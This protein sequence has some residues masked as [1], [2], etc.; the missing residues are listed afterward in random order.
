MDDSS[1]PWENLLA[2]V[3]VIRDP[4]HG[5]IELTELELS[6]INLPEFQRLRGRKQ[7]GP[8]DFVYPGAVHNRFQH[9]LG[10]V[11]MAEKIIQHCNKNVRL[12][13]F[14]KEINL[15]DHSF[16]RIFALIHDIVHIPF[17]HTLEE[18]GN[19]FPSQWE[20]EERV[21]KLLLN[22]SEII[23]CITDYLTEQ[24]IADHFIDDFI[25]DLKKVVKCKN[26][27]AFSKP[28]I[29]DI[30]NNTVCA[31][32]LDYVSR[33]I[34][35]TGLAGKTGDRFMRRLIVAPLLQIISAD[36]KN[37]SEFCIATDENRKK[38]KDVILEE[39]ETT[40]KDICH[41]LVTLFYQ[42]NRKDGRIVP[43]PSSRSEIIDLMRTRYSLAEKVYFHR[44]KIAASAMLIDAVASS[45]LKSLELFDLTD[46]QTLFKLAYAENMP[47]RTKRI[48]QAL[49]RRRL[50][51]P[52]FRRGHIEGA[53]NEEEEL[54]KLNE[55]STVYRDPRKRTGLSKILEGSLI[56]EDSTGKELSTEGS[57][58]I[59]CPSKK[60]NLKHFMMLVHASK[61]AKVKPLE[62]YETASVKQEIE[63]IK[64]NHE[65]LWSFQIFVD[66]EVVNPT[67]I[68]N[69][70]TI[71][72]AGMCEHELGLSNGIR[73]LRGKNIP[74]PLDIRIE[75]A[76]KKWDKNNPDNIL[77]YKETEL[78]KMEHRDGKLPTI[79][80]FYN[81]IKKIK[82]LDNHGIPDARIQ[83]N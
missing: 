5:D 33:D 22:E 69:W 50:Y 53:E 60:M 3:E 18:E 10:T 25:N 70:Q 46:E 65:A 79:N 36:G 19:L 17:G 81:E 21:K 77:A 45:G 48:A 64:K 43:S 55:V 78:I 20:D 42:I 6:I 35:F 61:E 51:K 34:L 8:T 41:R 56:V 37:T 75:Q 38:A 4:V 14:S 63:V 82:R 15:Y 62:K 52:I 68:S 71:S 29:I 26:P 23:R 57:I 83:F 7:L 24:E 16:I 32:L 31:D 72:L 12:Y 28:F 74:S 76:T 80:D 27:L 67:N 47:E 59:Y 30:V 39:G 1:K 9:S 73:Q 54:K 58:V 11:A 66:P 49:F 2:F 13:D 44:T 40:G